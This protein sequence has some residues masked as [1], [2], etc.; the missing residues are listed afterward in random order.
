MPKTVRRFAYVA[1]IIMLFGTASGWLGGLR[2]RAEAAFHNRR[3]ARRP[4]ILR[5]LF[6]AVLASLGVELAAYRNDQ[7]V[8][9]SLL[10]S[11]LHCT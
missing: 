1:L 8:I 9:A 10:R 11:P 3:V 4:A 2:W 6:A 5:K 7:D